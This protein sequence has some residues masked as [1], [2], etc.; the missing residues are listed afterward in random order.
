MFVNVIHI[1][2]KKFNENVKRKLLRESENV[3][4]ELFIILFFYATIYKR[5]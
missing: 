5:N 4:Y 3:S 2:K 1:Y